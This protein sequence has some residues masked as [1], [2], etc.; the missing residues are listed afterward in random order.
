MAPHVVERVRTADGK[1]LYARKPQNLGRIVERAPRRHDE[2]DDAGDAATGTARK[3]A[4]RGW[5]AAGKTGTSQDFRDA[6]FIGY[7]AHLVT[8][9]WLGN[10]DS[11]PSSKTSG[12]GLPVE[13]WNKFMKPAHQGVAV[14]SLPGDRRFR[15]G[16]R[17]GAVSERAAAGANAPQTAGATGGLDRLVAGSAVRAAL[18]P[19][20]HPRRAARGRVPSSGKP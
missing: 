17:A 11:S 5:P 8:G 13:I 1:T 19:A 12:S 9:V 4:L 14:A 16:E 7:T 2:R 10:D 18:T 3:A 15:D 20:D 6:W